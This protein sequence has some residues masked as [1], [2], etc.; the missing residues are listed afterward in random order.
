MLQLDAMTLRGVGSYIRGSRVDLPPLTIPSG[1]HRPGKS[2]WFKALG[3]LRRSADKGVLPF[4][5]DTDD[6]DAFDVSFMNYTLYCR[7]DLT[8]LADG[9]EEAG[10]GPP[11]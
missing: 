8:D 6:G 4:A 2:T 7:D 9:D 10:F 1:V 11:A 5:F 3:V